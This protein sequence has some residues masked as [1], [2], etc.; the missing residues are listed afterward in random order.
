ML[1]KIQGNALF[2]D[3]AL[4]IDGRCHEFFIKKDA[5]VLNTKCCSLLGQRILGTILPKLS[6]YCASATEDAGRCSLSDDV[7]K[8]ILSSAVCRL[9]GPIP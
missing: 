8:V 2:W 6:W 7:A 9:Y 4:F 5:F 1:M 3:H